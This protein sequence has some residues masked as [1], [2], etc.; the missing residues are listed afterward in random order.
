MLS[1][2]TGQIATEEWNIPSPELSLQNILSAVNKD[3]IAVALLIFESV[4]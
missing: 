3:P 4:R 1:S 2:G